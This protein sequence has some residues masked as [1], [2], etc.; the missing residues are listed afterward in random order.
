[1]EK[2]NGKGKAAFTNIDELW[3]L[4]NVETGCVMETNK[5]GKIEDER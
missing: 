1:V 3:E 2:I 5:A 4:V